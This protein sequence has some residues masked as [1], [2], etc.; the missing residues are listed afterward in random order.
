[1]FVWF[2]KKIMFVWFE[3]VV[4]SIL[5]LWRM[6]KSDF[7]KFSLEDLKNNNLELMN[8]FKFIKEVQVLKSMIF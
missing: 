1:M 8:G 6:S 7:F 2:L 5:L 4:I 3:E